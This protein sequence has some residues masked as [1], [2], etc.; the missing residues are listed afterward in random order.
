MRRPNPFL[1][2]HPEPGKDPILELKQG[3]VFYLS[4]PPGPKASRK[5]YDRF[6]QRWG[7]R[8]RC[9]TPTTGPVR[10]W[11]CAARQRFEQKELPLLRTQHIWGYGFGSKR[12]GADDTLLMFHGFRPSSEQGMASFYRVS[13]P[14][15]TPVE[16][17]RAFAAE[18][19]DLTPFEWG[20]GGYYWEA[21]MREPGESLRAMY[22]HAQRYWGV[23]AQHLDVT[24]QHALDGLTS[25]N[26]LTLIGRERSEA[27][28]GAV[29]AARLASFASEE[30]AHG[31][32]LQVEDAPRFID[33]NEGD[34]VGAYRHVARALEPLQLDAHG[35][36]GGDGTRWTEDNTLDYFRRFTR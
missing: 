32:L 25:I 36:F 31:V 4:S 6:M 17:V 3:V 21:S 14:W 2:A 20:T 29:A 11:S 27:A 34:L 22:A 15:D 18:V 30:R 13:L 26:W 10:R 19:A 1:L 8:V 9:Y 28:V 7:D 24:V 35:S 23:A 5:V 33:R 12:A 16:D